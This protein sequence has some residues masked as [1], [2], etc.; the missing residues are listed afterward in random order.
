MIFKKRASLAHCR[1]SIT[2]RRMWLFCLAAFACLVHALS[3]ASGQPHLQCT[4]LVSAGLCSCVVYSQQPAEHTT[5]Y[6]WR[7][8][9]ACCSAAAA[10]SMYVG[11][12]VRG[13]GWGRGSS[14]KLSGRWF[15]AVCQL[16]ARACAPTALSVLLWLHI[17]VRCGCCVPIAACTP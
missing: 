11:A 6:C 10:Y 3:L 13:K 5:G 7:D 4:C 8:C 12:A 9:T 16:P 15:L 17:S 2:C 1:R 14:R